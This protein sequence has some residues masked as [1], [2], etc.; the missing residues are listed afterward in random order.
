MRAAKRG[1]SSRHIVPVPIKAFVFDA[2]DGYNPV[3][4]SGNIRLPC[5]FERCDAFT[6]S[7]VCS[8]LMKSLM[9][10]R[11]ALSVVQPKLLQNRQ[12]NA[13]IMAWPTHGPPLPVGGVA[14]LRAEQFTLLYQ[15][16]AVLS[17]ASIQ[18]LQEHT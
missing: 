4:T 18:S 1:V 2:K 13:K 10:F 7:P 5:V 3:Y 12:R 6:L 14:L 17:T 15:S 9:T 16:L 8:S 11:P